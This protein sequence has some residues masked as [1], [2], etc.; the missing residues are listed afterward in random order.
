MAIRKFPLKRGWLGKSGSGVGV[1][2]RPVGHVTSR[3]ASGVSGQ[4]LHHTETRISWP[5]EVASPQTHIAA[6]FCPVHRFLFY[7]IIRLFYRLQPHSSI[8]QIASSP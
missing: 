3:V 2:R 1:A 4:K 6:T 8:R 7:Y 5:G